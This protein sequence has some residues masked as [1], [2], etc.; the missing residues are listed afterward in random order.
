ML[1]ELKVCGVYCNTKVIDGFWYVIINN[2]PCK[3][4]NSLIKHKLGKNGKAHA[5]KLKEIC[6]Y[7]GEEFFGL[8]RH[9]RRFCSKSCSAKKNKNS[10]YTKFIGSY[11]GSKK[12]KQDAYNFIGNLIKSNRI[13]RP[14]YCSN[15]ES[16]CFPEAHHPNYNKPNEV[17]WLCRSCHRKLHHDNK[18]KGELIIYN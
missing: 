14:N 16:S 12:M 11:D 13:I 15:C 6:E 8:L 17:I 1:G 4:Y 9:P 10:L 18:V 5:Y 2:K 3:L 7:C